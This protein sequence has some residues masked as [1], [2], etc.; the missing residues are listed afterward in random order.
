MNAGFE[1]CT[2]LD[3]LLEQALGRGGRAGVDWSALFARFAEARKTNTDAIAE[4]AVENFVEMRDRVG[5]KR[6]LLQKAVEVELQRRFPGQY[7]SRYGMVTFNRMPYRVALET[8]RIQE[9]MLAE[10]CQGIERPDQV[11]W[12][13]AERLVNGTLLPFLRQRGVGG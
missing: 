5:D 6:F 7:I 8:G 11:D 13:K 2:V 1:D 12:A 9:G 10:L 4:L 3:G